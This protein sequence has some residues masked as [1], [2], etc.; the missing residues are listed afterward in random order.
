M[1]TVPKFFNILFP[2]MPMTYSVALF[3]DTISGTITS[4]FWINVVVLSAI[5]VAFF[6]ATVLW[7]HKKK[8]RANLA[9]A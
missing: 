6:L 8:E 7:S 9:N 5:L 2:F 4:D 1:E 3:K